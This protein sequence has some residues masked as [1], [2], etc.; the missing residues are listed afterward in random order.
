MELEVLGVAGV[1]LAL[2]ADDRLLAAALEQLEVVAQAGQLCFVEEAGRGALGTAV[3]RARG[4]LDQHVT[5]QR[6]DALYPEV[7]AEVAQRDVTGRPRRDEPTLQH[8]VAAG[9][10]AGIDHQGP[11]E[12]ADGAVDAVQGDVGTDDRRSI[13]GGRTF[14]VVLGAQPHIA[15]AG[16]TAGADQHLG[17]RIHVQCNVTARTGHQV[18]GSHGSAVGIGVRHHLDIQRV[19]GFAGLCADNAADA[20]GRVEGKLVRDDPGVTRCAD[21]AAVLAGQEG[22]AIGVLQ[23]T[24]DTDGLAGVDVEQ[25]CIVGAE[26]DADP[27]V[28]LGRV[29][30]DQRATA[31]GALVPARAPRAAVIELITAGEAVVVAA[32]TFVLL[33][34]AVVDARIEVAAEVAGQL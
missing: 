32:A 30:D 6:L 12:R 31:R 29:G 11:G 16:A 3:D 17:C 14:D 8:A 23:N 27:V 13:A 2:V 18:A 24:I 4:G 10:L 20:A 22:P 34:A 7:A 9:T 28:G 21:D 19:G 1:D 5:G 25:A 15:T 33:F 26:A